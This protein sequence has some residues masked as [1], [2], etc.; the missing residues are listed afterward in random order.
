MMETLRED[1][2]TSEYPDESSV[3]PRAGQGLDADEIRRLP[4]VAR[5][6]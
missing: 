4:S 1:H 6:L 5:Q 3:D 2:G